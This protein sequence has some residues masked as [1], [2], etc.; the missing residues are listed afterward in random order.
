[1]FPLKVSTMPHLHVGSTLSPLLLKRCS[2]GGFNAIVMFLYETVGPVVSQPFCTEGK[3][4]S[5][6]QN[7]FNMGL[8]PTVTERKTPIAALGNEVEDGLL[9]H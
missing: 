5:C 2:P 4:K 3:P 6:S 9:P 7:R 8:K 1:M